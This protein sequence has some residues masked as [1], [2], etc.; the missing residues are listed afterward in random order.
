MRLFYELF[1]SRPRAPWRYIVGYEPALMPPEDLATFRRLLAVRTPASFEPWVR[2]MRPQDRLII[3]STQ[4]E[5]R[6][7][8]LVWTQVSATVWS[9]RVPGSPRDPRR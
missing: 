9:G 7:E 6:I 3:Q 5:P 2:K 1:Y 4:G 8:G